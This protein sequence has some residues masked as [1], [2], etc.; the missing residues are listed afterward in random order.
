MRRAVDGPFGPRGRSASCGSLFDPTP[1][2]SLRS[3]RRVDGIGASDVLE[4]RSDRLLRALEQQGVTG[5]ELELVW[6]P[7]WSPERMSE[8]ARL[9]LGMV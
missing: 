8:A 5:V 1:H 3:L 9:E 4:D 7:P 2:R 6:D